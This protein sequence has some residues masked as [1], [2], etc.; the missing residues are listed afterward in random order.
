MF[1]RQNIGWLLVIA[2]IMI[3][4]QGYIF[5]LICTQD[6]QEL[7][8]ALAEYDLCNIFRLCFVLLTLRLCITGC[9]R[10][11]KSAYT[12]RRLQVSQRTIFL[13]QSAFNALAYWFL[14]TVQMLLMIAFSAIY[15]HLNPR[16]VNHMTLLLTSYRVSL[17]HLVLPLSDLVTWAA[18]IVTILSLSLCAA[19]FPLRQ[20]Y[21][22]ISISAILM[23]LLACFYLWL[24]LYENSNMDISACI[25]SMFGSVFLAGCGVGGVWTTEVEGY[26]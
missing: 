11:G 13:L 17:F 9:D 2:L 15:S 23:G 12:Y 3:L 1:A 7:H 21:G 18:N 4:L 22:K 19:V 26:E 10:S 24:Q 5:A 14:F 6:A 8:I 25:I 16:M 20:R